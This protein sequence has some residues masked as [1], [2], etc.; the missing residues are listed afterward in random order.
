MAAAGTHIQPALVACAV[1][2]YTILLSTD[3]DICNPHGHAHGW[4][5]IAGCMKIRNQ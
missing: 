2:F 1:E 3:D 4:H 5:K